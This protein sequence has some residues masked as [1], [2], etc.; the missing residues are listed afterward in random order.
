MHMSNS[1]DYLAK[2]DVIIT[3]DLSENRKSSI[4]MD[5]SFSEADTAV[6][7]ATQDS[8]QLQAA[9]INWS[10]VEELPSFIGAAREAQSLWNSTRF[11]RAD[12]QTAWDNN[13]EDAYDLCEYCLHALAHAN[14]NDEQKLNRIS[15]IKEGEGG[16]NLVQDLNDIHVFGTEN[17]ASL[18]AIN[19]DF[20]NITAAGEMAVKM[21]DLLS[22]KDSSSSRDERKDIRDKAFSIVKDMVD[23][24]YACGQYVFWKDEE[25]KKLY[26]SA[27]RRKRSRKNYLASKSR[28]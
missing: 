19:F 20:A 27:Y 17:Q 23:E 10:M 1:A 4:P 28:D 8:V 2:L 21:G 5:I 18:D 22:I 12:A 9:G 16:A 26:A 6:Q 13:L 11:E 3:R 24:V 14:R 25:R 15:D 7:V